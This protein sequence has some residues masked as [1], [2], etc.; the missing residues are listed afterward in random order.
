SLGENA[1]FEG[2]TVTAQ[3]VDISQLEKLAL[4]N[5]GFTGNLDARAT[6]AGSVKAPSVTG[7]AAV[8]NGGFQNFKYQSLTVNGGY[9]ADRINLDARLVQTAGVELTAKGIVP[10]SALKPNPPGVSGHIAEPPGEAID[11]RVQS[12][13]IDLGIVQGFT[14]QLTNVTGKLLAD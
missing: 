10:T 13:N 11:V 9:T 14:N 4:M 2:I 6:I 7:R 12:T 5:R 1:A 3:K 8:S